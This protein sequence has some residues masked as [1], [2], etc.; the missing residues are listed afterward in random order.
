MCDFTRDGA[1]G[2]LKAVDVTEK[3]T[4]AQISVLTERLEISLPC[5]KVVA[6]LYLRQ[7][8]RR[9][10]NKVKV[11]LHTLALSDLFS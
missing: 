3:K 4:W 9:T 5:S 2:G 10:E 8:L 1:S 7:I 6:K 11:Y